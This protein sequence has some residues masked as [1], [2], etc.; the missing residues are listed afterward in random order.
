MYRRLSRVGYRYPFIG[1]RLIGDKCIAGYRV[2]VITDKVIVQLS[3][4]A[5]KDILIVINSS[6]I[7]MTFSF[8][9]P[10]YDCA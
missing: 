10:T 4:I 7:V 9:A 2:S 3:V 8:I 5:D 6:V 1:Y